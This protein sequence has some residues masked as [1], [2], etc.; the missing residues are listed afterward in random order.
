[1]ILLPTFLISDVPIARSSRPRCMLMAG[2]LMPSFRAAP[3]RLLVSITASAALSVANDKPSCLC[4][5][6]SR[7]SCRFFRFAHL[8]VHAFHAL[9]SV[10]LLFETQLSRDARSSKAAASFSTP[11]NPLPS[12]GPLAPLAHAPARDAA[13]RQ[14]CRWRL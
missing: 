1:M 2:W 5:F 9:S 4:T 13:G 11:A 12:S 3:V 14:L 8:L 10:Q 7:T 6:I